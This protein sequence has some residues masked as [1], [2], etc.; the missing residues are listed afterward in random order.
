MGKLKIHITSE[1]EQIKICEMEDDHLQ[2]TINKLV[3]NL[4]LAKESLND[5]T[6]LFNDILYDN[7]PNKEEAKAFVKYFDEKFPVYLFE[8]LIRKFD[9]EETIGD[10]QALYGRNEAV[11]P[12]SRFKEYANKTKLLIPDDN[13]EL[14]EWF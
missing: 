2:N 11:K 7:G 10:I 3:S 5:E 9:L 14:R 13:I 4:K 6:T 8:A 1:G 12:I